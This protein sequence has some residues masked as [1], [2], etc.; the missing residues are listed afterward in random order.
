MHRHLPVLLCTEDSRPLDHWTPAPQHPPRGPWMQRPGR[1]RKRLQEAAMGRGRPYGR[2]WDQTARRLWGSRQCG[3]GWTRMAVLGGLGLLLL[4]LVASG[5]ESSTEELES[6]RN[7]C[8]ES[9][10]GNYFDA[11]ALNSTATCFTM[12]RLGDDFCPLETLQRYWLNYE[13]HLV[14]NSLMETVNTSSV[15][16]LVWNFNTNT[17]EDVLFSVMPYQI[18]RQIKENEDKPT[19]R[20]RLPRS[21]FGSLQ[22][23]RAM[24]RLAITVLDIGPGVVFKGPRI[25][26]EDGSSVLNNR[27]VGVSVGQTQV[28][29]L[30]EPLE[31]SF[32]H[33]RQPPNMTLSCVFWDVSKGPT[34]DWASEGCSTEPGVE[35]TVCRCNHLTFFALLLRPVLDKTT[36]RALTHISQAGC[37]ASMI[38]LA[39]TIILYLV[40]RFYRQRFKSEDAP[41]VHLSLS[42]S[43]FLL[44]LVFFVTVGGGV[45]GSGAACWARGAAFHYFLLC[46]F[47][48]MGLEAFHL[49]LLVIKVFNTYFGRY[50]LK[51]S[52]VGWG[53]CGL[54]GQRDGCSGHLLRPG[55]LRDGERGGCQTGPGLEGWASH[56]MPPPLAPRPACTDGHRHRE[57]QQLRHLHHP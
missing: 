39:F 14:E 37:G 51:L 31:I 17:S 36:V 12:C 52:L 32:S 48:W 55:L 46:T 44:N 50:F 2:A 21:L 41:K 57:C 9:S 45:R 25:S 29:G 42:I 49:Y 5:S 54:N 38:F 53:R 3:K 4:L 28:T 7:P 18:P 27:L 6:P 22:G 8:L 10:I 33:K 30:G 47:T 40:L 35:G 15:K 1:V 19:D 43:L 56:A 24:V 23:E 11:L 16:S 20:V 34:G 13:S 26:Q